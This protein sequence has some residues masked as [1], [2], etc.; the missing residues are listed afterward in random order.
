LLAECALCAPP[1]TPE[2]AYITESVD[3]GSSFAI[4][5]ERLDPGVEV[6]LW[7]PGA[8]TRETILRTALST[9]AALPSVPPAE[10]KATAV[11]GR[12]SGRILIASQLGP[13]PALG[14][15]VRPTVA[16]VKNAAGYS[17]PYFFNRPKLMFASD[18]EVLPGQ[19]LRL[20]GRN[21]A[22]PS[23]AAGGTYDYPVAFQAA[24]G[25]IHWGKVLDFT[26][27]DRMDVKPYQ[28]MV[29]VPR[30]LLAGEYS[31][32]V[33]LLCGGPSA[34][35]NGLHVRAVA[36]RYWIAALAHL[37]D[38]PL[39]TPRQL[40]AR[41]PQVLRLSGAAGD[42]Y[43]DDGEIIQTAIDRLAGA[44]GGVVLLPAGSYALRKTLHV[45]PGVV[46]QGTGRAATQLV[47]AL[48][49]PLRAGFPFP[50]NRLFAAPGAAGLHSRTLAHDAIMVWLDNRS[51]LQD[52]SVIAGAGCTMGVL[53]G[54]DAPDA[55]VSDSFIRRVE[56]LNTHQDS[57]LAGGDASSYVGGIR[58]VSATSGF[59]LVDCQITAG[60]P[61]WLDSGSK[62]HRYALIEG[63]V[64]RGYPNNQYDIVMVRNLTDSIFE[65]N[66]IF[67]GRRGFTSQRGMSRNWI[68][69]NVVHHI[70]GYENG[71]EMFMSE[72]GSLDYRATVKESTG[73]T[74]VL[75][76][77]SGLAAGEIG[78]ANGET[79]AYVLAGRGAGQFRLVVNN[80]PDSITVDD[81]WT[82]E[83]DSSSTIAL[84][85]TSVRN[86]V[87]ANRL[88]D[89]RGPL[90]FTYGS[91]FENVIAGN[92]F[93]NAAELDIWGFAERAERAEHAAQFQPVAYNLILDNRLVTSGGIYLLASKS[94]GTK[95]GDDV[96]YQHGPLFANT[97][98]RNQVWSPAVPRGANQGWNVWWLQGEEDARNNAAL[99]IDNG[100]YNILESCYLYNSPKGVSITGGKG[101]VVRDNLFEMV[102]SPL[103]EID[104]E[105]T[106]FAPPLNRR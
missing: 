14:D 81:P 65:D 18:A 101:N 72:Y 31:V 28:L 83:P 56:I 74:L 59:S 2:I 29:Q 51:G 87:I 93:Y 106:Y 96:M 78:K 91:S 57:F 97:V 90:Q 12:P 25:T 88:T 69:G 36:S 32:R 37:D 45:R 79:Y 82:V 20:F 66:E 76:G 3:D 77:G 103:R 47:V 50:P 5:G 64:F 21:L 98:R 7:Q 6:W 49:A 8:D 63:N 75:V 35:S 9:V 60:N 40:T 61:L 27:Q 26:D 16:W 34:W 11:L 10:A 23:C 99:I 44:G 54:A 41:P 89:T 100:A 42:G 4:V 38:H 43:T 70:S 86:F 62:P 85:E 95:Y 15:S 92:E 19:R 102:G 48:H 67:N 53:V 46:L 94:R 104:T 33:H 52:L 30:D 55:I 22:P 105:G 17:R 39:A 84:I 24:S 80:T 73:K 1:A 58:V 71:S 68:C 13:F